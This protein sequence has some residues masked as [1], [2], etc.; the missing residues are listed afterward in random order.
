MLAASATLARSAFN[1]A[2]EIVKELPILRRE[3]LAGLRVAPYLASKF[4]VL[5]LLCSLQ[6]ALLLAIVAVRVDLPSSGILMPAALELWITLELA[7][8]AALGLGLVISA[9]MSN[10]DRA[11][12]LVPILLIPQLIFVGG[13]TSSGA[14]EW[15]SYLTVTHWASF[16]MKITSRIPYTKSGGQLRCRGAPDELGSPRHHGHGVRAVRRL[17][18]LAPARLKPRHLCPR[19]LGV[20]ASEPKRFVSE[21]SALCHR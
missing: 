2:R 20:E 16:A 14:S 6:T 19:Q 18:P 13:A 5:A 3:R 4:V 9:S 8:L 10:A 11:Q 21:V 12:S 15:L 17:A 7:A 1:A